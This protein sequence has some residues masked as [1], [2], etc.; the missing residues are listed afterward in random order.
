MAKGSCILLN[1]WPKHVPLTQNPR[2]GPRRIRDRNQGALQAARTQVP[3]RQNN[4][5]IIRLSAEEASEFFKLLNNANDYLK[6]R[7]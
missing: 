2:A 4:T 6:E 5:T 7:A 3:S 1:G